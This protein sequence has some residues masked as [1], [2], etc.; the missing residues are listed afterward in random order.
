MG[1]VI[2]TIFLIAQVIDL[3]Y[4]N[5]KILKNILNIIYITILALKF[6]I[7]TFGM[8]RTKQISVLKN[9][10]S[11]YRNNIVHYLLKVKDAKD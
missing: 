6:Q 8:V 4:S 5:N 2:F 9:C 1:I 7:Q 11:T 10:I 3:F